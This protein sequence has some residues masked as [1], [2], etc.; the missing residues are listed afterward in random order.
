M[1]AEKTAKDVVDEADAEVE[2][3]VAEVVAA[4]GIM[5]MLEMAKETRHLDDEMCTRRGT[6]QQPR[7]T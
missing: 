5:M 1:A 7:G 3:A 6:K 4:T 2:A